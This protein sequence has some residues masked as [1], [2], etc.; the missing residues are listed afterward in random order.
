MLPIRQHCGVRA[1]ALVD[2]SSPRVG[3]ARD[4]NNLSHAGRVCFNALSDAMRAVSGIGSC[5]RNASI[6]LRVHSVTRSLNS[7]TCVIARRDHVAS[8]ASATYEF[9]CDEASGASASHEFSFDVASGASATHE[10]SCD[11]A[12][13]ASSSHEFSCDVASGASAT[14]KFFFDLDVC[15]SPKFCWT[16]AARDATA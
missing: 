5:A 3:G 11:V 4:V 15:S 8:G 12:S 1:R 10:F 9:S 13:G 7:C 16:W 14:H 6:R 2:N